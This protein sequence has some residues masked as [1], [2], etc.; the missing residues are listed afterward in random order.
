MAALGVIIN[1]LTQLLSMVPA[2]TA[3]YSKYEAQRAQ[4]QAWASQ[5]YK[6]TDSDWAALDATVAVDEAKIDAL[7]RQS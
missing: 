3:L 7:T 2:G 1:L 6:P 5:N 4:A